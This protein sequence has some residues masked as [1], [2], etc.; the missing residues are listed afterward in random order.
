MQVGE[1]GAGRPERRIER[2]ACDI[3]R[4]I[5]PPAA[6][7]D[8]HGPPRIML[9]GDAFVAVENVEPRGR[10]FIEGAENDA[11]RIG[12]DVGHARAR[13]FRPRLVERQPPAGEPAA[14]P[15]PP[16]HV[17]GSEARVEK[18]GGVH[19]GAVG[20]IPEPAGPRR[21]VVF[22]IHRLPP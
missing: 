19:V 22:A 21:D 5:D 17:G 7:V 14:D 13:E 8:R 1:V 15:P 10:H 18:A 11:G 12:R 20:E 2:A 4:R 6:D 3:G 9:A 16:R